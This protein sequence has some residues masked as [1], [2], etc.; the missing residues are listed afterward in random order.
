[1]TAAFETW[2]TQATRHLSRDAATQVRR[3]IQE[4]YDAAKEDAMECGSS[5]EDAERMALEALGDAA[6]A[7]RQYRK[8]MLTSG[9]AR[10]LRQGNWEAG[11]ICSRA[12]LKWL[13][14]ALPASA[15]LAGIGFS[16]AGATAVARVLLVGG[17]GLGVLMAATVLPVYTPVRGR[18]Y[19][20]AKWLVLS[21]ILVFAFWPMVLQWSWLLISCAWPMVWA[22]WTR[23]SIRRKLPVEKW[24]KQLYL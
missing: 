15:L 4:H 20:A 5:T 6:A 19:R 12:W 14:F 17:I 8:V 7:N 23:G 10:L 3:E 24:P 21:G 22:E 11:A 2:L 16:I 18:I 13:L 1:M 9:E